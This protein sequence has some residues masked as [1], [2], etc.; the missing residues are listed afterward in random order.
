MTLQDIQNLIFLARKGLASLADNIS[1]QDGQAAYHS[2][3][4]AEAFISQ[5]AEQEKQ[6]QEA[7]NNEL[8]KTPNVEVIN[9][10]QNDK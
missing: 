2:I 10:N 8:A 1:T 9:I 3:G 4:A 5:M 6:R 7:K